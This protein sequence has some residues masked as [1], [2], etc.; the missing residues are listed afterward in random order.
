MVMYFREIE[1][2][3]CGGESMDDFSGQVAGF[4]EHSAVSS[5]ST[6]CGEFLDEFRKL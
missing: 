6:K 4:S 5:G 2:L 3:G 1:S